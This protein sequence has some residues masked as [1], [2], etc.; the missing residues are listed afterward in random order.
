[1]K[2]SVSNVDNYEWPMNLLKSNNKGIHLAS[3]LVYRQ[4]Q[5]FFEALANIDK[6]Y[7]TYYLNKKK[8]ANKDGCENNDPIKHTERVFAYELYHQWSCRINGTGWLLNAEL[9]KHVEWF[10]SNE[11]ETRHSKR[12][13]TDEISSDFP[14]MVLHKGQGE[15]NQLIVCEIKREDRILSDIKK[16]LD[17]LYKFTIKK[18]EKNKNAEDYYQAYKC[19]IF[20]AFNTEFSK[21]VSAIENKMHDFVFQDVNEDK[22]KHIICVSS[23]YKDGAEVPLVCY[24]SLGEIISQLKN[25]RI[26]DNPITYSK[27]LP[28][29]FAHVKT[30]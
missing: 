29:K 14:D 3:N 18:D 13:P 22:L 21:I 1:M 16:D 25:K 17:R 7:Y 9:T 20:L 8:F 5:F 24:Q 15:D 4:A 30:K 2:K 23:L 28:K 10:Y 12:S 27:G 6:G 19:G 26:I 11:E